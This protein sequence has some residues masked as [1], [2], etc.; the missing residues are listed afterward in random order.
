MPTFRGFIAIDIKPTPKILEFKKEIEKTGTNVKLVNPE[1]IHATIKFLGDTDE[2]LVD[3]IENIMN[4]SVKEI[5]LFAIKLK[6]AGAFP[7]QNYIKVIWIGIK[8]G[9]NIKTIAN[10]IDERMSKL[11]FKK[12]KGGFSPH[13]TI[14]RVKTAKNK[15]RL[16][17]TIKNYADVE[18]GDFQIDC[19]K[20]KKSDLT[21]KGP[22]YT[23]IKEVKL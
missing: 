19:I 7:N 2:E 4:D 16:V 15:E 17:K 6:G 22:I 8:N 21:P 10:R 9:Q 13:L 20:L 11:G 14:G 12:E 18:F 23:T 5:S 1:N 3:Q